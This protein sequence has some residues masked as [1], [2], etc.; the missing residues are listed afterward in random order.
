MSAS[1]GCGCGGSSATT[2]VNGRS[3]C[4]GSCAGEMSNTGAGFVRPRFFGGMLLTEDDLQAAVDYTIAKRK[5]TNRHVLGTGVVSGLDVTCHPCEPGKVNVSPGYAIEGCGNDILVSCAEEVDVIALVRDL[6]RRKDVDCDEPCKDQPRQDYHLYI[7][8]A[9]A[10]TAPVAPYASDD[11]ATGE[12]EFSRISEGYRFELRCTEPHDAPT[13]IDA[14]EACQPDDA[15]KE[16]AHKMAQVVRLAT[17]YSDRLAGMDS[18]QPIAVELSPD[19]ADSAYVTGAEWMRGRILH[20]LTGSGQTSCDD[21]RRVSGLRFDKLTA[22]SKDDAL[23]LAEAFLRSIAAPVCSA[24]NPPCPSETDDAVALAKVHV[25]G[26]EVTDICA[27]ERRWV[28]SPRALGYWF[29]VVEMFRDCLQQACCEPPGSSVKPVDPS[30]CIDKSLEKA[31]DTF[32]GAFPGVT[33]T[34]PFGELLKAMGRPAADTN[35]DPQ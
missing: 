19:E 29:P 2:T 31:R 6:R 12:C 11:C 25:D 1:G 7:R 23:A 18:A 28:L 14:L 24:F 33:G 34:S 21:Y 3:E 32:D 22:S 17:Q 4:G 16:D 5:L 13:V 8:Y 27:L 26:C 15:A 30:A 9:E 35:E 10:P 20:A